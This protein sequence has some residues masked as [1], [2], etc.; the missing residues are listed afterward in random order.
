MNELG[1][2]GGARGRAGA[3]VD[4]VETGPAGGVEEGAQIADGLGRDG[5]REIHGRTL[6]LWSLQDD[7]GRQR[8]VRAVRRRL[9]PADVRG[10]AAKTK[11]TVGRERTELLDEAG[12]GGGKEAGVGELLYLVAET[13]IVGGKRGTRLVGVQREGGCILPERLDRRK[14][15]CGGGGL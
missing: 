12:V 3:E 1:L 4:A 6:A 14:N 13:D 11:H 15:R 2:V 9:P 7:V 5:V 8:R 10:V